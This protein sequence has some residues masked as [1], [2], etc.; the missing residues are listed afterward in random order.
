M[1]MIEAQEVEVIEGM[2]KGMVVQKAQDELE[3]KREKEP[4]R[5]PLEEVR[6]IIT[7]IRAMLNA[8]TV[9]SMGIML[10]K[11]RK[12]GTINQDRIQM[13]LIGKYKQSHGLHHMQHW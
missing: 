11:V 6:R 10:V 1:A 8:T 3:T 4:L 2:G 13:W 5:I 9:I 7:Q 12:N